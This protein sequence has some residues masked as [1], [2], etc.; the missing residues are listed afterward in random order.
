MTAQRS[1]LKMLELPRAEA[2]RAPTT[3]PEM[4]ASDI[5]DRANA[6][7]AKIEPLSKSRDRSHKKTR[8]G[9]APRP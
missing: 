4:G 5:V 1:A 3:T 7:K 9:V 6:E 2:K 8:S